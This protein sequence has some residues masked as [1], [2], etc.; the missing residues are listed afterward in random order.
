M[1]IEVG[2]EDLAVGNTVHSESDS[3]IVV[4]DRNHG[5]IIV[6][7]WPRERVIIDY[8]KALWEQSDLTAFVIV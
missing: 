4:L 5:E 2:F 1:R 6:V 8:D 7:C 3:G